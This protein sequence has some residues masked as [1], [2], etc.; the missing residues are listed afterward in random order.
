MPVE[1]GTRWMSEAGEKKVGRVGHSY[2]GDKIG[3]TVTERRQR[4]PN[5]TAAR[6]YRDCNPN[7]V[8]II[9]YP[10]HCAP[11]SSTVVVCIPQR[12][13]VAAA[14]GV[15]QT[16]RYSVSWIASPCTRRR[17]LI[18]KERDFP[19]ELIP[20]DM[21]STQCSQAKA[22]ATHPTPQAAF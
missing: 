2:Y 8:D 4:Q 5:S 16:F 17:A 6:F 20:V 13:F 18:A 11:R 1:I 15:I 7:R 14:H 10:H 21:A 12:W 22:A 3:Q 19:Y 9:W